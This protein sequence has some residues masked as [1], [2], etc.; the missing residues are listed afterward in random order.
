VLTIKHHNGASYDFWYRIGFE[1]L[2]TSAS[3][4]V[5]VGK[6]LDWLIDWLTDWLIMVGRTEVSEP[7]PSLAYCSSPG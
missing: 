2:Y 3:H 4:S 6:W 5:V 7:R 1:S